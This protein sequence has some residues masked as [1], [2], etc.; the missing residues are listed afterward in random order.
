MNSS[1]CGSATTACYSGASSVLTSLSNSWVTVD[2]TEPM[3]RLETRFERLRRR[4]AELA[5][6]DLQNPSRYV[7]IRV[8]IVWERQRTGRLGRVRPSAGSGQNGP[9]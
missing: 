9:N 4:G 2:A 8:V 3:C 6:R 5:Q 1:I 7:S